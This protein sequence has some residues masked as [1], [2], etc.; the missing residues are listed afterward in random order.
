MHNF[1][2][3]E[4]YQDVAEY[5]YFSASSGNNQIYWAE[6]VVSTSSVAGGW[7]NNYGYARHVRCLRTLE[8]HANGERDS[9]RFYDESVDNI[10]DVSKVN[11]GAL[12][13]YH[14]G[15]FPTHYETDEQNKL[16]TRFEIAPQLLSNTAVGYEAVKGT[17]TRM[18]TADEDL[19]QQAANYGGA[20]R[21]PNARELSLMII[22]GNL[23]D[24]D[25]W[26]STR[27]NGNRYGGNGNG[28][29]SFTSTRGFAYDA[30]MTISAPSTAYVRCVRDVQVAEANTEYN[31]GGSLIQ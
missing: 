31:N 20:W 4:N 15:G 24:T 6:E 18:L 7:F 19:C 16:Y 26:A 5:H 2:E 29:R 12:R 13:P 27:F 23:G 11:P 8:S 21:V 25:Y 9:D 30:R 22:V 14:N 17:A 10:V 28:Y 3:G 1:A